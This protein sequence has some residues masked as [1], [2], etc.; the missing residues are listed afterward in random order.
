MKTLTRLLIAALLLVAPSLTH[1]QEDGP[2]QVGFIRIV[3]AVAP[4][5]GLANVF[6]DGDD[7]FP[8]G[9]Q[10]GQRTGGIGAHARRHITAQGHNAAHTLLPIR[11]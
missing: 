4:G 9:Y 10:L 3:N 7:I 2:P 6:V 5:L 11:L 8:K 1:A